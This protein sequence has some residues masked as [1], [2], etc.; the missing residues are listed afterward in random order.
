MG[1]IN[2]HKGRRLKFLK[3]NLHR[4]SGFL[5]LTRLTIKVDML[6]LNSYPIVTIGV[7]TL[8][9]IIIPTLV[10][11][12][13]YWHLSRKHMIKLAERIPGP[14]GWPLVGNALEFI[15]SSHNIFK[16]AYGYSHTYKSIA[17]IWLGPKLLIF[18]VDPSD[19]EVILSSSVHI[20]KAKEY[21]LFQPWFG[22]GLLISTGKMWKNHRK[23]I[24]PAFHLNVLKG[25]IDLFNANS[26]EVIEKLKKEEGK[27]FDCHDYMSEATV[28][29]LLETV[30]GV[31]KHDQGQS[32]YDYA[33]AVMKMCD[34]IHLR[35]TKIWLRP[36]WLFNFTNYS[37]IQT[38]LLDS[39]HSLTKNVVRTKI[40]AFNKGIRGSIAHVPMEILSGD[41]LT[42]DVEVEVKNPEKGISYGQSLGIKDD[43]DLDENDVGE[44]KRLPFLELMIDAYQNR[45][46][47][48]NQDIKDQ[49]STILFEGHDTTAAASSF[50]LCLMAA[51]PDIQK[52]VHQEVDTIFGRSNRPA[53]FADTLEMKYLEMCLLETLR[54]Y[55]PV[56]VIAREINEDVVLPSGY[57]LP[58]GCTVV[59][60]TIKTHRNPDI[61][62]NPDVFNPD[63]FLP[64]RT[65]S[66]HYYSFIPFSAGP[67][68]CVGRKYAILKLKILLSTIMR[69]FVVTSDKVE[70]NYELQAD[71]ILKRADGFPIK[72]E[73]RILTG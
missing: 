48:T 36:T 9:V 1:R 7:N 51:H 33:M 26:R 13:T 10:V 68:S 21:R 25:F 28:E 67:R 54:L 11:W 3:I 29:V 40:E 46:A 12:Y 14:K 35:H 61:Y 47:L 39:L 6:G 23:L 63:H 20:D 62:P 19:I 16:T 60:G 71:I 31:S 70:N 4:V 52:R 55:P 58:A 22:N 45:S 5:V 15:G 65:A 69:N 42:S 27:T 59:I 49:V 2:P 56:P 73:P 8:Y 18:L 57:T 32:G 44:K 41:V 66:R 38:K 53:T 24:A 64:V 50:F 72:L 30:M 34:I 17:K 43:I 37:K